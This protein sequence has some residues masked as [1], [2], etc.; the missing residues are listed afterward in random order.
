MSHATMHAR[1]GWLGTFFWIIIIATIKTPPKK[2]GGLHYFQHGSQNVWACFAFPTLFLRP[3]FPFLNHFPPF[4]ESRRGSTDL[5]D[6]S[7]PPPRRAGAPMVRRPFHARFFV[8]TFFCTPRQA[9]W[10]GA[11]AQVPP[12]GCKRQVRALCVARP[13]LARGEG[14]GRQERGRHACRGAGPVGHVHLA[15]LPAGGLAS[16]C[17]L[18]VG[19]TRREKREGAWTFK[20]PWTFIQSHCQTSW[21]QRAHGRRRARLLPRRLVTSS[22]P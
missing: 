16:I 7:M 1:Q 10:K 9:V 21:A 14:G 19:K 8:A 13:G 5:L 17:T 12:K 3:R 20:Q 11:T 15:R 2:R 18:R 22:R 6:G 4:E